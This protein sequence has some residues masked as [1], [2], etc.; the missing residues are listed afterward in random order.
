MAKKINIK[1]PIV[2]NSEVWIYEWFGIEATSPNS[3]SKVIDEA[4]GEDLEVEINSGGGSVFAGSEIYTILKDYK[5]HVT[6]KIVD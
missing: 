3:V 4:N 1:G 5:G 6:V 2:G